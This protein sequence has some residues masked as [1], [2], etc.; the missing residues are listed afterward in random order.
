[1]VCALKDQV[2]EFFF[3]CV[4]GLKKSRIWCSRPGS[5]EDRRPRPSG[6]SHELG[7][8]VPGLWA[9]LSLFFGEQ[10]A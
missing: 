6:G 7:S 2:Q 4:W 3:C 8:D 1:M 5:E 10:G 9:L